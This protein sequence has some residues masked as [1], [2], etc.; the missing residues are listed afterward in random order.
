MPGERAGA[1]SIRPKRKNPNLSERLR[2]QVGV[3]GRIASGRSENSGGVARR[4]TLQRAV[5]PAEFD[6]ERTEVSL[7]Q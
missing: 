3:P 1:A 5:L 7:A 4:S 2:K 6:Y